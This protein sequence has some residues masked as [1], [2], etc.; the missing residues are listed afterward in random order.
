MFH[1][2]DEQATPAWARVCDL[3]FQDRRDDVGFYLE[4]ASAKGCSVLEVG[5]S[6]GRITEF[7]ADFRKEVHAVDPSSE[8]STS[9]KWYRVAGSPKMTSGSGTFISRISF[10]PGFK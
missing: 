8:F 7:L 10:P 2:V 9:I 1:M 4:Q 3:L 5:C 6:T